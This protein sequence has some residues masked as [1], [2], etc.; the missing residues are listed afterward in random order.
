MNKATSWF[1]FKLNITMLFIHGSGQQRINDNKKCRQIAGDFDGHGNA[2]VQREAHCPM[3]HIQASLE[4]T[5]RR[6]RASACVV[7]PRRPPW[8]TISN[9]THETLTNTTFS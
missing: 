5:G 1:E 2:A 3:E 6:H 4:A 7:S 8:L 9:K